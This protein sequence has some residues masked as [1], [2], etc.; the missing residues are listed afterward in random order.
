MKDEGIELGLLSPT[1]LTTTIQPTSSFIN[2][3]TVVAEISR[4]P[5]PTIH[6]ISHI[7]HRRRILIHT[8]PI[9]A[10]SMLLKKQ[11]TFNKVKERGD[12]DYSKGKPDFMEEY[13]CKVSS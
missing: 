11:N 8:F 13:K 5:N 3:T 10:K 7:K 6:T 12:L 2:S 4:N 1:N 9:S